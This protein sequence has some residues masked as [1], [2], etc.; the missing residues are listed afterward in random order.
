MK[1]QLSPRHTATLSLG[2]LLLESIRSNTRETSML[3]RAYILG[4]W[5]DVAGKSIA[6]RTQ[7]LFLQDKKLFVEFSSSVARSEA[8]M[9]RS[10]IIL[11]INE[12]AQ[13]NI[14]SE[15]VLK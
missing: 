10:E 3:R 12:L 6:A 8:L 5:E 14:V 11:R 13:A 15:L 4:L 7:Q 9:R 1:R 2:D